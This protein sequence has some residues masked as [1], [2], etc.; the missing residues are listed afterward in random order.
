M[1]LYWAR[2]EDAIRQTDIAYGK[3]LYILAN[4]IL[5]HQEDAQQCVNDTYWNAWEMI[6]PHTPN[7]F[8]A[9]L[10]KLCRKQA[11]DRAEQ[12]PLAKELDPC[13]PKDRTD[14]DLSRLL[15]LFLGSISR[16][17]RLIFLRRYWYLDTIPEIAQR[18]GCSEH[19]VK[20]C[21]NRTRGRLQTFLQKEGV[22]L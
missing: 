6:P 17:N 7:H 4:K 10:A 18:F 11:F 9:F 19:R 1:D 2:D 20:S 14:T 8:F 15:N 22:C 3:K 5:Q 13:A 16:E 21:L 12:V